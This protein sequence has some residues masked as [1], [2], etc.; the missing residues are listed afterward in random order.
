MTVNLQLGSD[1]TSWLAGT[2]R[3]ASA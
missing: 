3:T 1:T 2:S